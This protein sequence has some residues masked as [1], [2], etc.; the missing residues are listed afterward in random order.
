MAT[1]AKK[2]I[3]KAAKKVA[4]VAKVKR[5]FHRKPKVVE[6]SFQMSKERSPFITFR[7]TNQTIYWSTL[8]IYI[9]VLSIWVLNIQL[10]TLEIINKIN[11]GDIVSM[12]K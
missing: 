9:L 6:Q 10:D 7:V 8:A 3:K 12:T 5:V 11:T 4:R 2:T 1:K